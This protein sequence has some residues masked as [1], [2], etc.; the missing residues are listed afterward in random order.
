MMPYSYDLQ[1]IEEF[2]Q[3]KGKVMLE[4]GCGDGQLSALL[5]DKTA[6]I[7]AIDTDSR[8]IE[9]ARSGRGPCRGT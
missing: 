7:T 5:A 9:T 2:I 8:R 1:K 3:L 6:A 4:V